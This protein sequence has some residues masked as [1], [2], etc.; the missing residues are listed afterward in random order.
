MNATLLANGGDQ[1]RDH[2]PHEERREHER[3]GEPACD[4]DP[5]LTSGRSKR[6]GLHDSREWRTLA[7]T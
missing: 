2:R 7:L 1:Q 5:H 3:R 6:V 4:D